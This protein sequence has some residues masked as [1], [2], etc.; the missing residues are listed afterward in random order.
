MDESLI[1]QLEQPKLAREDTPIP[2]PVKTESN[3]DDKND[4]NVDEILKRMN[5]RKKEI[6]ALKKPLRD[7]TK[8]TQK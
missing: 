8:S 2:P 4:Q 3:N 7:L 6:D 1:G 5:D